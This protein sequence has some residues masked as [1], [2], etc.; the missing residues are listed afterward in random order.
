MI[1]GSFL[2]VSVVLGILSICFGW[3]SYGDIVRFD[4]DSY[5][6]GLMMGAGAFFWIMFFAGSIV[7]LRDKR[8]RNQRAM[9]DRIVNRVKLI[10]NPPPFPTSL[11]EK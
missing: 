3:V 11:R 2:R 4:R 9:E 10:V 7:Y 5:L 1:D 8:E 6:L